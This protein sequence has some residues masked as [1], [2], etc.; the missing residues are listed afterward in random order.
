MAFAHRGG[1]ALTLLLL[2]LGGPAS[3]QQVWSVLVDIGLPGTWATSCNA[4]AS[5]SNWVLNGK[6]LCDQRFTVECQIRIHAP[7]QR[8][9]PFFDHLAGAEYDAGAR[10]ARARACRIRRSTSS[11]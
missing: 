4:E 10:P 8:T 6:S 5:T 9:N 11:G 1:A 3:A 2:L 7:Q